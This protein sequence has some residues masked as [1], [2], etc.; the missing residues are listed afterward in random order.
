M[1]TEGL[2]EVES[3]KVDVYV[4]QVPMETILGV[5]GAVGGAFCGVC[6][7]GVLSLVGLVLLIIGLM[8][9]GDSAG[10]PEV[11]AWP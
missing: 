5:F 11:S 3:A 1:K 4:A 8:Q 7:G 2:A 9:G 10:S 6:G